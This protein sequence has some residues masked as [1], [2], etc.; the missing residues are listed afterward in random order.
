MIGFLSTSPTR[1]LTVNLAPEQPFSLVFVPLSRAPFQTCDIAKSNM[2]ELA[3]WT[4]S[5]AAALLASH[6][7]S[8]RATSF[9]RGA[10]RTA[11]AK[12]NNVERMPANTDVPRSKVAVSVGGDEAHQAGLIGRSIY[13]LEEALLLCCCSAWRSVN[14]RR[15]CV[16]SEDGFLTNA[17]PM[18]RRSNAI[19][20]RRLGRR[21][22][23]LLPPIGRPIPSGRHQSPCVRERSGKT[24]KDLAERPVQR[25]RQ[26]DGGGQREH[27]AHDD[28]ANR[29][30]L[31]ARAAGRH[32]A[33][34]T[35]GEHV[36]R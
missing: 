17:S 18:L 1:K 15:Y 34:D 30:P 26:H 7:R 27:P 29:R 5:G 24:L 11:S 16:W 31:Q 28:V 33:G 20:W 19:L 25:R 14:L 3:R 13:P 4:P 21:R 22:L 12:A 10:N 9:C 8:G 2:H 36:S 23:A 35:G 32:G 6:V